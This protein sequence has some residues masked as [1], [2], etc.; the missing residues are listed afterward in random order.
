M[1]VE[2]LKQCLGRFLNFGLLVSSQLR[3]ELKRANKKARLCAFALEVL[4][5]AYLHFLFNS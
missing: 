5:R 2:S 3:F 4:T 1:L